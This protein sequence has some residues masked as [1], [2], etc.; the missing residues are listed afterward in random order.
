MDI[1][2]YYLLLGTVA[3]GGFAYIVDILAEKAIWIGY[4]FIMKRFY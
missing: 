1:S 3:F 4:D 2:I